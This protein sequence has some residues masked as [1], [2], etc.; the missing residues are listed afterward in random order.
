MLRG[1]LKLVLAGA[2]GFLTII[3]GYFFLGLHPGSGAISNEKLVG[4][5]LL[6]IIV[7]GL[8]AWGVYRILDR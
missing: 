8:A 5:I 4:L 1:V 2:T 6:P 7:G 3:A